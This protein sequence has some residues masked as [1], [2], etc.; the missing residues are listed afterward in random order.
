MA[1]DMSDILVDSE[2]ALEAL[3]QDCRPQEQWLG[4][5]GLGFKILGFRV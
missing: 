3:I 1:D 2:E 5:L 4:C